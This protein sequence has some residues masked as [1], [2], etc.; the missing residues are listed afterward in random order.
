MDFGE[1]DLNTKENRVS[2]WA[3]ILKGGRQGNLQAIPAGCKVLVATLTFCQGEMKKVRTNAKP[4][5]KRDA[6]QAAQ[7]S[8]SRRRCRQAP[9]QQH[10]VWAASWFLSCQLCTHRALVGPSQHLQLHGEASRGGIC[11]HTVRV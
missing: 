10:G 7:H 5:A 8:G 9:R 1:G 6:W 4:S 3:G 2:A 11:K